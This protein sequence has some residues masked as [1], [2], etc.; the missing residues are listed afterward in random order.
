MVLRG[1][2]HLTHDTGKEGAVLKKVMNIT[3]PQ[4]ESNFLR[5]KKYSF[6]KTLFAGLSRLLIIILA[7]KRNRNFHMFN[8][9]LNGIIPIMNG[10]WL[11]NGYKKV[12]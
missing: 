12:T 9:I 2:D 6:S 11:Q 5:I 3:V 8:Q 7:I 1:F 4:N 10:E